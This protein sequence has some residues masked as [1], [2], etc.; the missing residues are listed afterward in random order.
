[1]VLVL[2]DKSGLDQISGSI[3]GNV[4]HLSLKLVKHRFRLLS[5]PMIYSVYIHMHLH[6]CLKLEHSPPDLC[7]STYVSEGEQNT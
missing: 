7:V 2:T 4:S 6:I 5:I 1:M 3:L